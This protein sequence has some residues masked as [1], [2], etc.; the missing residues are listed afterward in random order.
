MKNDFC[1]CD[2]KVRGV[3][4]FELGSPSLKGKNKMEIGHWSAYFMYLGSQHRV[5][6]NTLPMSHILPTK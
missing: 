6:H 3:F 4:E 5:I 1:I 2:R